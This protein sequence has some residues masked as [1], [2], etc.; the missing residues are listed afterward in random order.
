MEAASLY[1]SALLRSPF[2][3]NSSHHKM[4]F[5]MRKR[6]PTVVI[7]ASKRDAYGR[8]YHSNLVDE[9][10]IVLRKR[11]HEMEMVERNHEPPRDWMEWERR[12]YSN[13]D[14][15]ICEAVGFLQSQLMN[16]RPSL[17]LGMMALIA[18]SVPTSTAVIV[19][20]LVE[21]AKGISFAGLHLS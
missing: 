15:D 19:F 14:S 1:T 16:V 13:Y 9:S 5:I 8:D 21:L 7:T 6:R 11:I 10:M 12:Y 20:H 18:L 17:A 3:T 4:G 2:S